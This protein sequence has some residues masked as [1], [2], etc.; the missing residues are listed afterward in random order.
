MS[1]PRNI[2]RLEFGQFVEQ[3]FSEVN[4]GSDG[5]TEKTLICQVPGFLSR[6]NQVVAKE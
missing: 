3:N 1:D 2:V 4:E 5:S 6:I